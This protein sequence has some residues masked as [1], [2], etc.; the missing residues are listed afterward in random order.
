MKTLNNPLERSLLDRSRQEEKRQLGYTAAKGA[1][2]MVDFGLTVSAVLTVIYLAVLVG[3]V[4]GIASPW[5]W[6]VGVFVGV[7]AIVPAELGLVIWRTFLKGDPDITDVQRWTAIT[8]MIFAGVFSALT[9]SSFFS[10]FLPGLFT[11]W[12]LD[13]AP[14]LNIAAIVGS[15]IVFI[16]AT[17]AWNV[18]SQQT[19]QNLESAKA[20]NALFMSQIDL[21]KAYVQ[22]VREDSGALIGQMDEGNAFWGDAQKW[23]EANL[24][25][26]DG[27]VSKYA[28]VTVEATAPAPPTL[29]EEMETQ[30]RWVAENPDY[31]LRNGKP[32]QPEP[33]VRGYPAGF[34]FA[35]NEAT[36]GRRIAP[37]QL[38][39][40]FGLTREQALQI[41]G[42][43]TSRPQ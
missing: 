21:I 36:N 13:I 20:N 43:V 25:L 37:A 19:K 28:P 23:A 29:R 18:S 31:G 40:G 11:A 39:D 27:R 24:G 42:E 6:L 14:T 3:E 32:A 30:R 9:T 1:N 17:V 5:N 41:L 12:Y 33:V 38:M 26:S 22:A 4:I 7:V 10:Y 16:L 2:F 15:W 35:L 34:Q 8:A